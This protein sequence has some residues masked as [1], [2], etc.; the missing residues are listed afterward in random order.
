MFLFNFLD[1]SKTGSSVGMIVGIVLAVIVVL[2]IIVI[3]VYYKMK[4]K[5]NKCQYRL[6][7]PITRRL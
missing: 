2:A 6:I 1:S 3:A 4:G 7:V 5:K